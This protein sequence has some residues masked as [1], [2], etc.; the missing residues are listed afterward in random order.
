MGKLLSV[1]EVAKRLRRNPVLLYRW[2][3]EGRIRAQKVGRAVVV[4]EREVQRFKRHEPERRA[5]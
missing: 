5:R 4:D 1:G 3:S 2:I